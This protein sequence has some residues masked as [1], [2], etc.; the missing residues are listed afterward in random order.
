[1][2]CFPARSFEK[3]GQS[4]MT[5]LQES[6]RDSRIERCNELMA[7]TKTTVSDF[8]RMG[9]TDAQVRGWFSESGSTKARSPSAL[10]LAKIWHA[11]DWSPTYITFGIGAKLLSEVGLHEDMYER[12]D[13]FEGVLQLALD[14]AA[15]NKKRYRGALQTIE[16]RN[17]QIVNNKK[18]LAEFGK[19]IEVV[20]KNMAALSEQLA[21]LNRLD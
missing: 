5:K 10:Q 8:K 11:L 21:K 2:A 13:R 19:T 17:E 12:M 18:T 6:D 3:S 7:L 16:D 9:F 4:D 14:E 1:V 15:A 20:N